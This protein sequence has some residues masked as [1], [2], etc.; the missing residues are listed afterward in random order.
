MTLEECNFTYEEIIKIRKIAIM[1]NC[2]KMTIEDII[3][4]DK[5][6]I[7]CNNTSKNGG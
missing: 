5:Q 6:T 2:S 1:F 4:V 7:I 3:I